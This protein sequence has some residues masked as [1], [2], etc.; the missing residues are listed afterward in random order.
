M[1]KQEKIDFVKDFKEIVR[2]ASGVIFTNFRGVGSDT[3]TNLRM[4]LRENGIKH[5]VIKNTLGRL[6]FEDVDY[7]DGAMDIL[8]EGMNSITIIEDDPFTP[9]RII[10][11]FI[12]ENEMF[13]IKGCV[14]SGKFLSNSE[15]KE[16]SKI[17]SEKEIYTRFVY[18]LI[19]PIQSLYLDLSQLLNRLVFVVNAIAKSSEG[20]EE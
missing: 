13:N 9:T 10:S 20:E 2:D 3:L 18:S 12:K 16:F 15:L 8:N 7:K 19:S 14:L 11:D 5:R 4:E 1:K 17:K 6:V